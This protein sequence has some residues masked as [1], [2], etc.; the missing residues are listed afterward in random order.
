[1]GPA[2]RMGPPH[3]SLGC[4]RRTSRVLLLLLVAA[5]TSQAER[6]WRRERGTRALNQANQHFRQEGTALVA[7]MVCQ[8]SSYDGSPAVS[9]IL[10]KTSATKNIGSPLCNKHCDITQTGFD[11]KYQ[12]RREHARKT[13]FPATEEELTG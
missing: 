4:W 6:L 11:R 9:R 7:V 3:A 1:M 8:Q 12:Q 5:Q 13:W 10:G 2:G